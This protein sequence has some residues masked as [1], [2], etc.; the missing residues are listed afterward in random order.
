MKTALVAFQA[1][2]L[3]SN[4]I[5]VALLLVL[6]LFTHALQVSWDSLPTGIALGFAVNGCVEITASAM[7]SK[8]DRIYYVDI[9]VLRMAGFHIC[10]VIWLVYALM[11]ERPTAVGA[12]WIANSR[13]RV[14][15]PGTPKG[16][17]IMSCSYSSVVVS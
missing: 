12:P 17:E 3:S 2:D 15:E 1:L 7:F 13:S 14:L 10:V 8:L 5:K 6:L 4:V 9:D 16:C 11:P